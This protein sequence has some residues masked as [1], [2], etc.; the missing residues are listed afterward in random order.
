MELISKEEVFEALNECDEVRGFAYKQI[1]EAIE[2]IPTRAIIP[3]CRGCFG[4]SFGDCDECQ[5]RF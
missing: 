5:R 4:A 3:D 1:N 2:K